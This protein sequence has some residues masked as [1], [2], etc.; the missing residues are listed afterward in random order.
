MGK[1]TFSQNSFIAGELGP[2]LEGRT[3]VKQYP[4]GLKKLENMFPFRQGGVIRRPGSRFIKDMADIA[5]GPQQAR[6]I[7]FIF[8]KSEAYTVILDNSQVSGFQ[9]IKNDG[10][11]ASVTGFPFT[12]AV[13]EYRIQYAQSGDFLF[14]VD[15]DG[16]EQP[17]VV[18]RTSVDTFVV[19]FFL[20]SIIPNVDIATKFIRY[21]YLNRNI[22]ATTLTPNVTTGAVTLTASVAT[23][24]S[25][26]SA[27]NP[28]YYRLVHGAVEGVVRLDTFT[29]T[30]IA[31]GTVAITLGNT[32][33]TTNWKESAWNANR[34]YPRTIALFE[35]RLILGGTKNQPDTIFGSLVN[36]LFH[37]MEERLTQ[38]QAST[39]IS[40]L[41]YFGSTR[42]SDPFQF[43]ILSREINVIQW[44]SS[45]K[46][47][48]VGTLGGEYVATGG[49]DKILSASSVSIVQQTSHG[50]SP[51]QPARIERSVI[52]NSRDGK[53]IRDFFFNFN[54]DSY[55]SPDLT[56]L[57]DD[58]LNHN[59]SGT[60]NFAGVV[61]RDFAYQESRGILWILT[62]RNSLIG[63]T[64]DKNSGI[65]AWHRHVIGGTD[66]DIHGIAVIP[67][68][69]GTFDDIWIMVERTI[70]G[71]DAFYLE[72][73]GADFEHEL[74]VNTSTNDDDK[75]W[76]TDS[77]VRKVLGAPGL[78]FNGFSHLIGE[79][80]RV[81]RDGFEHP[82]VVVNAAGGI[83]LNE[84][85]TEILAG[86]KYAPFLKTM[87]LVQSPNFGSALGARVRIDKLFIQFFKT[88]GAK[89]GPREDKLEELPFRPATLPMGDPLHM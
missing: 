32:T 85:G 12:S 8:S 41:N 74:L 60:G 64:I 6:L 59:F 75:P 47:L 46:S 65:S 13:D 36:N 86:L 10:T 30:T 81:L 22:S 35:G 52:F 21:A 40:G 50:S 29:S 88:F 69:L 19:R 4:Q 9:I 68:E 17:Q 67:N 2:R 43:T 79:T 42:E 44:I 54:T 61:V 73:M 1:F 87:P 83:V 49:S 15:G 82:D 71:G 66:V 18:I 48:F 39:D 80:V 76:F 51:V 7:P 89:F 23:F 37:M 45:G 38:D 26:I 14:L 55:I 62:S 34:G 11:V 16:I 63:L 27:T 24:D 31:T 25:G 28:T 78:T 56:V 57:N 77:A 53:R 5:N 20:E 72:K 58:I 84:N 3:D 33:A 70:D